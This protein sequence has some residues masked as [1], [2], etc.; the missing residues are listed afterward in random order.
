MGLGTPGYPRME[1]RMLRTSIISAPILHDSIKL[2]WL[3]SA[4]CIFSSCMVLILLS[5]WF[6][7]LGF[8]HML[9]DVFSWC[10]PCFDLA[11]FTCR[12]DYLGLMR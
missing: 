8:L 7:G 4:I 3:E 12:E 10:S 2:V 9:V 5:P 11:V 6:L 1:I